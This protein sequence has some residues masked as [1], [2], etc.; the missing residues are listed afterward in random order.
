[1]QV[2]GHRFAIVAATAGCIV[3]AVSAAIAQGTDTVAN[4][5]PV[6]PS[7]PPPLQ[8]S[9]AQRA[10]I[11]A[12]IN[13][14]HTE[15]SADEFKKMKSAASF[16]AALGA[17]LPKGILAHALPQVLTDELPSLKEYDYVKFH[18]Q[19]LIVNPVT[20]EIVNMIPLN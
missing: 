2:F 17:K 20:T 15:M 18:D 16:E 19:I 5:I 11:R 13:Q 10:Q 4:P 8:L 12:A 1:M 9:D 3:M 7:V 14:E 6:R